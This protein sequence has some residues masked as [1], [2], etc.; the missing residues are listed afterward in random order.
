MTFIPKHKTIIGGKVPGRLIDEKTGRAYLGEFVQDYKGNFYK[1]T[2]ITRSSEKLILEKP[3]QDKKEI[4]GLRFDYRR[5]KSKD[6]ELGY[7]KRYFIKDKSTGKVVEVGRK[8]YVEY[9]KLKN[10][11]F[12]SYILDWVIQG[13]VEDYYVNDMKVLGAS[14]KN[15]KLLQEAEKII[16]GLSVQVLKDTSEF[17]L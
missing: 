14:S 12:V 3:E 16:P 13:P 10:P 9:E 2:R 4:E 7:F 15:T 1:G 17:V 8:K 6:Y 5:P 11:I